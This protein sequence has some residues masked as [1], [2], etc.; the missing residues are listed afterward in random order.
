MAQLLPTM[1][2]REEMPAGRV[3]HTLIFHEIEARVADPRMVPDML[4][5]RTDMLGAVR[6]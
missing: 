6:T 3:V 5:G 2:E 4:P 1:A